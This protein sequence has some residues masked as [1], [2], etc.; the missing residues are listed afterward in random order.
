MY[1]TYKSWVALFPT[2]LILWNFRIYVHA[3]YYNNISFD[4]ESPV[5]NDLSL[6]LFYEP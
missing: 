4:I 1:L 6:Y 3:M 2:V 5:D